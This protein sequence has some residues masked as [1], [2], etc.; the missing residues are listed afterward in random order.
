MASGNFT[1][2]EVADLVKNSINSKMDKEIN[3]NIEHRQDYRNYKVNIDRAR[4][5]L[6]FKPRSDIDG[7]VQ[8]LVNNFDK[9]NDLKNKSYYNIEVFKSIKI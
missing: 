6:S 3:L 5:I 1:V 4:N 2:G 8:D 9:F 7:I